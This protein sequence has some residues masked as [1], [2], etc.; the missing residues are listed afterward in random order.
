[1]ECTFRCSNLNWLFIK[2]FRKQANSALET[3]AAGK[4]RLF[5][6]PKHTQLAFVYVYEDQTS[7][8]LA[9][10][11]LEHCSI[12]LVA[13]VDDLPQCQQR[14]NIRIPRRW[15]HNLHHSSTAT[16]Q[17][18]SAMNCCNIGTSQ[19]S[20]QTHA[21]GLWLKNNKKKTKNENYLHSIHTLSSQVTGLPLNDTVAQRQ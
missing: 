4:N 14:Q 13:T 12:I 17:Q 11:D 16:L 15:P 18:A 3:K 1:M 6:I 5:R 7:K 2:W 9:D 21:S 10:G 8:T 19:Y 20:C